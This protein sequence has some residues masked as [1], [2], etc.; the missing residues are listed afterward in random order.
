MLLF[1]LLHLML[2]LQWK[3]MA[4]ETEK[5]ASVPLIYFCMESVLSLVLSPLHPL[6]SSSLVLMLIKSWFHV[7][8]QPLDLAVV[9]FVGRTCS[10][11]VPK[12]LSWV[13]VSLISCERRRL[14]NEQLKGSSV[15][16]ELLLYWQSAGRD[17]QETWF[18][19]WDD[20]QDITYLFFHPIN[21]NIS[22]QSFGH[23]WQTIIIEKQLSSS[24]RQRTRR[25]EVLPNPVLSHILV[26]SAVIKTFNS[27]IECYP[28][29]T[30][31]DHVEQYCFF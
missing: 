25:K 29:S 3:S 26:K 7:A 16:L 11:S 14:C 22:V 24:G 21:A 19:I 20:Y 8:C 17:K 18:V 15:I 31:T 5:T 9:V 28:E 10:S 12:C 1:M 2:H 4:R 23:F 13:V 30:V 6:L 27:R